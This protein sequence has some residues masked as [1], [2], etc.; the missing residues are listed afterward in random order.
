MALRNTKAKSSIIKD[1]L[2][3]IKNELCISIADIDTFLEEN[4]NDEA[5][6]EEIDSILD[7]ACSKEGAISVLNQVIENIKKADGFD[8][9]KEE[10][11]KALRKLCE[12]CNISRKVLSETVCDLVLEIEDSDEDYEDSLISAVSNLIK[13]DYEPDAIRDLVS[14]VINKKT[15]KKK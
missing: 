13:E 10:L 15:K 7:G 3:D 14:K 2:I 1:A 4:D 11:D 8:P 9:D 6:V 5:L 12:E